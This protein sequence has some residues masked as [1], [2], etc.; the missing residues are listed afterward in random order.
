[1]GFAEDTSGRR[2][3]K[4]RVKE[5]NKKVFLEDEIQGTSGDMAWSSDGKFLFYVKRDPKKISS[6][7][8]YTFS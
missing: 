4:I 7:Y 1:M 5:L 8:V 2:L 3:Y 6:H